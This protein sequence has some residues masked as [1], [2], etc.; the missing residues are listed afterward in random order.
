MKVL[1]TPLYLLAAVM[2]FQLM[3]Q[4]PHDYPWL[5][6][7]ASDSIAS[8]FPLPAGFTRRPAPA[9]SFAAWLR[10]LP[11]KPGNPPVKLY[12]GELKGYQGG[13]AAVLDLDVGNK[14]LQQCADGVIRLRAEFLHASAQN[15]SL[16]FNFTSGDAA[17]WPRWR[18]WQ[19][20]T[21]IKNKVRW[22]Q[23]AIA[24]DSYANFKNYLQTVFNYAG[25]MSLSRQLT[26]VADPKKIEPG[27]VFIHGGSPGHAVIVVDVA[28]NAQGKRQFMIA[29]SY[30]PAQEMH[31]L[32]NPKAGESP[33]YDAEE[34]GELVTPEWTFAR[35]ELKRFVKTGC[36]S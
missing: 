36:A 24:D 9:G 21:V 26:A 32:K 34:T 13:H 8:R 31:L 28:E 11:L 16:C 2:S 3:A 35:N 17:S 27:D 20:P 5:A 10:G 19:R 12:N 18:S 15:D 1:I 30:M 33:W 14:D 25:S 6:K 23:S 22:N 4:S 29:Q 7:P